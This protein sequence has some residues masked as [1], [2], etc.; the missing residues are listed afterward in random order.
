[1]NSK[2]R[3]PTIWSVAALLGLAA[4]GVPALAQPPEEA[5]EAANSLSQA[6]SYVADQVS[7][8]VVTITSERVVQ[9]GM[10]GFH[11]PFS[12]FFERFMPPQSR[13]GNAR[14]FRQQGLGSGVIVDSD[15]IILTANH[16]VED[17]E[18]I[19]VLLADDRE[20]DAEVVG[21]DPATDV[22]VLRVR[23]DEPL[24]VVPIAGEDAVQ[25]GEW[26]LALGNPFG[27]GLRGTV[28]AGIISAT[29]R[30]GIGLTSYEDFIQTDAAINPGNSGGPLVNLRGELIGINTAIATR[31]GGYQ[32]VGFAIPMR[33]A[34]H[35]MESIL[36][37]G[38]VVRGWL[39]VYI[40]DLDNSLREAFGLDEGQEG[41]LVQEVQADGPARSGGLEDGDI[42]VAMDG[43]PIEDTRHL[44]FR[45]AESRPGEEVTFTV[46]RD[47]REKTIDIELGELE[48]EGGG[49]SRP[50]EEMND[51]LDD[52]GFTVTDLDDEIRSQLG[53]SDDTRGVVV[54]EVARFSA[55][56]EAGLRAGDVIIRASRE[57]VPNVRALRRILGELEAGEVLLLRVISDETRR[58]VAIRIPE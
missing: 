21:T 4:L 9:V 44:R 8:S 27:P 51:L 52:L 6:F 12:D 35:V 25:V 14:E 37:D 3:R 58:F 22:A 55:A 41:V 40:R 7:P 20:F 47:G 34:N 54:T 23:S 33:L 10:G 46:L 17:A 49:V 50:S 30:T 18:N 19:S 53:L 5:I 32:G 11:S 26:V 2:A 31:T 29:G 43:A 56:A 45:V 38:R 57:E 16:V 24:P 15:G 42:I 28:T 1:M 13:G 36:A 39:G 48:D